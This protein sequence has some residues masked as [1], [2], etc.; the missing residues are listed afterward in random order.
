MSLG[1]V[2]V[3]TD[4][5]GTTDFIDASCGV[6]VR[7]ALVPARDPR[8]VFEAPG[9]VWAEADVADAAQALRALA[10]APERCAALGAAARRVVKAKLGTA[11]LAQALAGL[12]LDVAG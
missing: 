10:D 8:G 12:G 3:A 7:Y 2:V 4:W 11:P 9:A 5:S 1:R 6:P